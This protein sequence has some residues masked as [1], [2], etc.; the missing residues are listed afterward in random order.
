M[1]YKVCIH[2]FTYNH[3]SYIKEALDGFIMQET[4]FPFVVCIVDDASTDGE[5]ELIQDY[6]KDEFNYQD[7][8]MAYSID[9]SDATILFAR[10]K[11][12]LNCY[13]AVILL[14]ENLYQQGKSD[15]KL[16]YIAEWN[17]NAEY[18]A[19]CEGDDFWLNSDKLQMQVDF[20]D[21]NSDYSMCH[22]DYLIGGKR[23]RS[24]SYSIS[25]DI[26]FPFSVLNEIPVGTATVLYRNSDYLKLPK[27]WRGKEWLMGDTPLFIELSKYGK[28]KYLSEVTAFYRVLQESASHGSAQ[29]EIRFINNSIEIHQFYADYYN[30]RLPNSGYNDGYYLA[31]GK[32]AFKHAEKKLALSN[33]KE[34]IRNHCLSIKLFIVTVSTLLPF[35][36]YLIKRM[37][38]N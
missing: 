13:F 4:T 2:C 21:A 5:S 35:T 20:M 11:K 25:N 23:R 26:W 30:V 15:I 1:K 3:V 27:L 28:I 34:A 8:S 32:I 7:S 19:L 18:I 37:V 24:Y 12:N 31:I 36:R 14:K 38:N 16:K 6:F 29:K 9:D 17:D 33:L 22:T 10:H